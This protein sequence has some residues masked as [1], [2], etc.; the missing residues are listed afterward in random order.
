MTIPQHVA[1]AVVDPKAY[2]DGR[3][4]DEAF[5]WLRHNAPLP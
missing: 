4:I 1:D 5:T 2:A 3:R